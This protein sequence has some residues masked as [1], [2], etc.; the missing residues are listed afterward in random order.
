MFHI[1]NTGLS[2]DF[3]MALPASGFRLLFIEK[4][5]VVKSDRYQD[6]L[7]YLNRITNPT[8]T[9]KETDN[10]QTMLGNVWTNQCWEI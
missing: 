4:T 10:D 1:D 8:G 9:N 3:L 2:V 7:N 5:V 6:Q